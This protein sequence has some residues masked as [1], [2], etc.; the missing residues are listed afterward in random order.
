MEYLIVYLI[1]GRAKRYHKDLIN[2]I[3]SKFKIR[4]LNNH[5]MSHTTLKAPFKIKEIKKVENF[6]N[7]FCKKQ[8]LSKIK[9]DGFG[10]F[11]KHVFYLNIL[12]SKKASKIYKSLLVE[13][14]K[15]KEISFGE[16]DWLGTFHSTICYVKDENQFKKIQNFVK[17][18]NPKYLLYLDNIT[19]LK[20]FKGNWKIHKTFKIK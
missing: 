11:G 4:N 14:K 7:S 19:I 18:R 17:G 12:F 6:L 5:M 13:L 16:Y 8:K 2:E 1:R 3:S 20:E 15:F 9:I 10:N